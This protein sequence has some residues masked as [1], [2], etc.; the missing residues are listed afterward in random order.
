VCKKK[1]M[2]NKF[3]GF[4][5]FNFFFFVVFFSELPVKCLLG[6]DRFVR[7]LKYQWKY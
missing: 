7:S 1:I 4:G 2:T 6:F 3:A 5:G